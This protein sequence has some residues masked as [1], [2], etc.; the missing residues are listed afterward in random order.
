M[1]VGLVLP[2]W[3]PVVNRDGHC[4]VDIMVHG[5][6]EIKPSDRLA[7]LRPLTEFDEKLLRATHVSAE[8]QALGRSLFDQAAQA[9]Q[10]MLS[11]MNTQKIDVNVQEGRLTW[12][13]F[14]IGAA[15]G[16]RV[17]F[18]TARCIEVV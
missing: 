3:I 5:S 2:S 4:D 13:V 7:R 11:N 16:G 18:N 1:S 10:E 14:I 17:S 12:L 15:V 9:Y 8:Q 6:I